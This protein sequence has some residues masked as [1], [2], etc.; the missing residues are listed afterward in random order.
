ME[1][2]VLEG[3]VWR[4]QF[5]GCS[6]EGAVLEGA[7]L[8]GAVWR[9]QFGG[10]SL[11][12]AVRRVQLERV[13]FDGVQSERVQFE[14]AV[15]KSEVWEGAVWRVT[16]QDSSVDGPV[17]SSVRVGGPAEGEGES[18]FVQSKRCAVWWGAV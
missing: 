17:K 7:V 5:G 1:G 11:E 8:E 9:V 6:L 3:A 10:Y 4:V 16:C 18:D 14:G 12:G 2:A 15:W 13:Q